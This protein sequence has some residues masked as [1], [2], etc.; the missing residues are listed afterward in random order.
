M[1]RGDVISGVVK[2]ANVTALVYQPA[3]GVEAII[4][5]V[6]IGAV[7][8]AALA[9]NYYVTVG[10]YDGTNQASVRKVYLDDVASYAR[11]MVGL[12]N[13]AIFVTNAVYFRLYTAGAQKLGYSGIQTK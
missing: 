10:I 13:T 1:A 3:A 9:A 5:S 8:G 4:K 7:G 2:V 12:E 6:G 11:D